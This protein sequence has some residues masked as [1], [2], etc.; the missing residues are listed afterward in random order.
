MNQTGRARQ[1]FAFMLALLLAWSAR[2]P[3]AIPACGASSGPTRAA[4]L[5]LY[6]SEGCNSCPPADRWLSGLR[7]HPPRNL[8]VL[9]FHVDYWNRLGW[10]DRFSR[11]EYSARQSRIA[12]RLHS[13]TVYT[14]Q[15]VL[16]GGDWR[17]WRSGLPEIGK[18]RALAQLALQ[19]KPARDGRL[20]VDAKARLRGKHEGAQVYLVLYE[21]DLTSRIAAGENA[22]SLLKHDFVARQLLG[23]FAI[24][25]SGRL[26]LRQAFLLEADWKPANLGVAAFI[27]NPTTGEVLQ[28]LQ[29]SACGR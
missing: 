14:P 17:A 27:Q 11:P 24:P 4:L 9:A 22:G 19:L 6:T 25:E 16:D 21:N 2:A 29:R 7:A 23:P 13:S 3:A 10:V 12:K 18:S 15:F 8:V 5:E 1:G 20:E 26:R 28:A